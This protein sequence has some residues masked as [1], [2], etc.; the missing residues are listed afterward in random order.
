MSETTTNWNRRLVPVSEAAITSVGVQ[1]LDGRRVDV[2]VDITAC[3][4]PL[5]VEM[6]IVGPG[7]DELC[8]IVLIDNREPALDKVMHLREDARAG[9][10]VLHVG[11]FHEDKL[12]AMAARSFRFPAAGT[13]QLA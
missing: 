7:D 8:S 9:E 4:A 5:T 3:S 10:H 1:A 2:A 6:V 12:V 13:G 11:L